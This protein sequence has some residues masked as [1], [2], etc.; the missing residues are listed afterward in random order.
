MLYYTIYYRCNADSIEQVRGELER[1][2][3]QDNINDPTSVRIKLANFHKGDFILFLPTKA[4]GNYQSVPKAF[5]IDNQQFF[6]NKECYAEF[7]LRE[8]VPINTWLI[9][10][11]CYLF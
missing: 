3:L 7:K 6:L 1:K 5:S 2:L 8:G 11:F 4:V 10:Q 9:G